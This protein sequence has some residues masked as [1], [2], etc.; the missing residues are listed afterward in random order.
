MSKSG[1]PTL[2]RRHV[3]FN[4]AGEAGLASAAQAWSV[5]HTDETAR[6]ANEEILGGV[7]AILKG[8]PMVRCEVHGE[9]GAA[10]EAPAPLAQHLGLD[11]QKDVGEIMRLLARYRA[12][13]CFDALVAKGVPEPQLFVTASGGG[14]SGGG[15]VGVTFIPQAAAPAAAWPAAM[16]AGSGPVSA[17]AFLSSLEGSRPSGSTPAGAALSGSAFGSL[18]NVER[19]DPSPRG[20]ASDFLQSLGGS[21]DKK[22]VS[23][24]SPLASKSPVGGAGASGA[25]AAS[26][27]LNSNSFFSSLLT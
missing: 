10:R 12:Q 17:S 8:Y 19:S 3:A 6:S 5:A 26:S 24:A 2:T 11:A 1:P 21:E 22:A 25:A 13:A 18:A 15:L 27:S 9:T 23:F 7:A 16:G 20:S 14:G 4:G